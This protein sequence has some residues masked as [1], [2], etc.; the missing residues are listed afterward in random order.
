MKRRGYYTIEVAGKELTGHFSVNFWALMEEELGMESL[1]ETFAFMQQG[2]GMSKIRTLVYCSTKAHDLEQ[3][4]VPQFANV[5][6]C[7]MY[8]EDF[9]DEHLFH[10]MEAFAESKLLG[11]NSNF[12]IER[13]GSEGD[14]GD[15]EGK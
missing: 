10:V 5:F 11:N 12:G 6:Q 1:A 3:G 9:T 4:Q 15:T 7:G 2:I 13:K 8:L 14:E